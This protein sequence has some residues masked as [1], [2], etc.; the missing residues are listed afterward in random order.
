[1]CAYSFEMKNICF[2]YMQWHFPPLNI[3]ASNIIGCF[4]IGDSSL[5]FYLVISPLSLSYLSVFL[6]LSISS[7][8]FP[9]REYRD[10]NSIQPESGALLKK[11]HVNFLNDKNSIKKILS[12]SSAFVSLMCWKIHCFLNSSSIYPSF[13]PFF[14]QSITMCFGNLHT[15]DGVDW[16][17]LPRCPRHSQRIDEEYQ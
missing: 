4:C 12:L 2:I 6:S 16:D 17:F 14:Q 13:L 8:L 3:A 7:P 10:C 5:H 11:M 15:N 9:L 1:M